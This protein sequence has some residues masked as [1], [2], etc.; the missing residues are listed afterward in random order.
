MW[1]RSSVVGAQEEGPWPRPG[2]ARGSEPWTEPFRTN[3]KGSCTLRNKCVQRDERGVLWG[4]CSWL[5]GAGKERDWRR[6]RREITRG[7]FIPCFRLWKFF[8]RTHSLTDLGSGMTWEIYILERLLCGS[9]E[10][11]LR[12]DK[13]HG[14]HWIIPTSQCIPLAQGRAPGSF[15]HLINI[16]LVLT[17]LL[18]LCQAPGIR[19][20]N[21]KGQ[22]HPQGPIWL[23]KQSSSPVLSPSPHNQSGT[24]FPQVSLLNLSILLCSLYH[25]SGET[26]T[27]L[28]LK[29]R[30]PAFSLL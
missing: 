19:Q 12:K 10:E 6:S 7:L 3:G 28:L 8:L 17:V 30:T 4:R 21:K 2:S 5:D 22:V 20:W 24:M 18:V 16:Y 25:T 27:I 9:V 13:D 11:G 26:H 15:I 1:Q 14:K 29:N 23:E